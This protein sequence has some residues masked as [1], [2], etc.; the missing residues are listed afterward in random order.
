MATCSK[1]LTCLFLCASSIVIECYAQ[2]EDSWAINLSYENDPLALNTEG[3]NYTSSLRTELLTSSFT[4]PRYIFPRLNSAVNVDVSRM[5]FGVYGYTPQNTATS[6]VE[7][8]DRPYGSFSYLGA[9]RTSYDLVKEI[10]LK[11]ELQVGLLG[12][13]VLREVQQVMNP[14]FGRE[15]PMGWD[16]QVAYSESFAFSYSASISKASFHSGQIF[17]KYFLNNLH[18]EHDSLATADSELVTVDSLMRDK[19]AMRELSELL[20]AETGFE[21]LQTNLKAGVN[22]GMVHDNVFAAVE[23]NL[24]NVNRYS[25]LNYIPESVIAYGPLH[26][27]GH[28]RERSDRFRFNIFVRPALKLVGYN[29]F[30]EGAMFNDNSTLVIP[31]G[32]IQRVLFEVEA[33]FNLLIANRVTLIGSWSGR[34]REYTGGRE[35]N[36]WGG[37]TLGFAPSKWHE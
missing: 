2:S 5:A 24:F 8:D 17:L 35:F 11:S 26:A 4:M 21:F 16:N 22:A 23:F 31:H 29:A 27:T 10:V 9:G 28:A 13:G 32:D 18:L 15:A 33:G 6:E 12:T 30:L 34:S 36:T 20:V 25:L 14:V 1:L 3:E 7:T 37:L 19:V